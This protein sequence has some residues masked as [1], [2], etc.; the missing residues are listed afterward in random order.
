MK[1]NVYLEFD[2]KK[3]AKCIRHYGYVLETQYKGKPYTVTDFGAVEGT[4]NLATIKV[5]TMALKRIAK[6]KDKEISIYTDNTYIANTIRYQMGSWVRN[7][8]RGTTGSPWKYQEDWLKLYT[9]IAPAAKISM[10]GAPEHSY[11]AWMRFEMER[12][13][14]NRTITKYTPK[15]K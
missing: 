3:K 8:Y 6:A 9:I 14:K 13:D 15:C 10:I 4:Y 11:S 1:I 2:K 7:G 12:I 5:M